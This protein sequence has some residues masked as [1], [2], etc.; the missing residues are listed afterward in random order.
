MK[1]LKTQ[2]L[3]GLVDLEPKS[4]KEASHKEELKKWNKKKEGYNENFTKDLNTPRDVKEKANSLEKS[5]EEL[6]NE[7][8][9]EVKNF[10][11]ESTELFH[12]NNHFKRNLKRETIAALLVNADL[13]KDSAEESTEELRAQDELKVEFIETPPSHADPEK[14][15]KEQSTKALSTQA[16]PEKKAGRDVY[17]VG[18]DNSSENVGE[19]VAYSANDDNITN[20]LLAKIISPIH[21]SGNGKEAFF[22]IPAW[23]NKVRIVR[24]NRGVLRF[25]N[26]VS[27]CAKRLDRGFVLNTLLYPRIMMW[28]QLSPCITSLIFLKWNR[29]KTSP[30]MATEVFLKDNRSCGRYLC[31]ASLFYGF[32]FCYFMHNFQLFLLLIAPLVHFFACYHYPN[33]S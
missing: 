7:G 27:R 30:I 16:D 15:S 10:E 29:T 6:F 4:K 1:E 17:A 8:A 12:P 14:Q 24:K 23:W 3:A 26:Y 19:Y 25:V 31:M 2:G 33:S 9:S 13:N 5:I 28:T 11:R 22:S 21:Q 20:V 32:A 18:S